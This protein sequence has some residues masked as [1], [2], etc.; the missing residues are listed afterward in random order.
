[1]TMGGGSRAYKY[2][3]TGK[4]ERE[5]ES[6]EIDKKKAHQSATRASGATRVVHKNENHQ[7]LS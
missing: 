3:R 7:L 1:M 2:R 6:M 5:R 4:R